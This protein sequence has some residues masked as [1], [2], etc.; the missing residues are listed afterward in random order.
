MTSTI[1]TKK[2]TSIGLIA[3]A[4]AFNIFIIR[5]IIMLSISMH[6]LDVGFMDW[7]LSLFYINA[8]MFVVFTVL[9]WILTMRGRYSRGLLLVFIPLAMVAVQLMAVQMRISR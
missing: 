8:A 2:M 9:S 6:D 7:P 3:I 4:T 5:Y 1:M